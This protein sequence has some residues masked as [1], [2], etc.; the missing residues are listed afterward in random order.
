[1]K[2]INFTKEILERNWNEKK[3]KFFEDRKNYQN[4][5]ISRYGVQE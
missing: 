3:D 1:M 5:V 4:W 2:Q